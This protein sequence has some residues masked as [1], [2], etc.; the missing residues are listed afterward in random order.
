LLIG[1]GS[2]YFAM[3]AKSTSIRTLAGL[4]ALVAIWVDLRFHWPAH[5][6]TLSAGVMTPGM[7]EIDRESLPVGARIFIAPWAGEQLLRSNVPN[8][9]QDLLGKRLAMW[10]NLNLLEGIANVGGAMTLRLRHQEDVQKRIEQTSGP[11]PALDYLAVAFTTASNNPVQWQ[12]R[13]SALSWVNAGQLPLFLEQG[14]ESLKTLV[15]PDFDPR[16]SIILPAEAAETSW[17]N[18]AGRTDVRT[19]LAS[20]QHIQIMVSADQAA[21]VSIAQSFH[22]PWRAT[23]DGNPVPLWRANHAFQAVQVP[24]GEHQIELRYVDRNFWIGGAFSLISGALCCAALVR[25]RF[26]TGRAAIRTAAPTKRG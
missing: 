26:V 19:A 16:T 14:A 3:S 2:L 5:N 15:G 23:L 20:A 7:S 18:A 21:V 13:T 12:S 17:P 9:A 22:H 6:P 4:A 10:S 11:M 1:L 24:S 25:W 8:P